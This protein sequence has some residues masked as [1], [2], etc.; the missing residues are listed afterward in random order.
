MLWANEDPLKNLV[1]ENNITEFVYNWKPG[2]N[3]GNE[4]ERKVE[5]ENGRVE[6]QVGCYLSDLNK[7]GV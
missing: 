7:Q 1:K 2:R 4:L 3:V 5:G 6:N